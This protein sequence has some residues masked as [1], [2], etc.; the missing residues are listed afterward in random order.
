M[1]NKVISSRVIYGT[2][3]LARQAP[4]G[5]QMRYTSDPGELRSLSSFKS[6][7]LWLPLS[8]GSRWQV[9]KRGIFLNL[10]WVFFSHTLWHLA[11]RIR[12]R[13]A[14][15]TYYWTSSSCQGIITSD[16]F[17][18]LLNLSH[19][20]WSCCWMWTTQHESWQPDL[21]KNRPYFTLKYWKDGIFFSFTKYTSLTFLK[22]DYIWIIR[23]STCYEKKVLRNC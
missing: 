23:I 18:P 1:N 15:A 12:E 8:V 7:P 11:T 5:V 20:F 4:L 21:W 14:K 19:Y 17:W 2:G 9:W 6:L 13:F 10:L 3:T 16:H 22:K